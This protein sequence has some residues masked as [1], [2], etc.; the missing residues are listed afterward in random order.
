MSK[1]SEGIRLRRRER[2]HH[3]GQ[4]PSDGHILPK[5][6]PVPAADLSEKIIVLLLL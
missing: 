1:A 5:S 2:A 6:L 3:P 4:M